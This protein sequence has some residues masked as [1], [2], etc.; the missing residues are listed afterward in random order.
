MEKK[1]DKKR[2][3][4]S[5][6][7][8]IGLVLGIVVGLCLQ[9][10]PD[11]ANNFIKPFGTLF[12]NLV[13]MCIVPLV[14]ASLVMGACGLG[15]IKKLGRVGGKIL[16]YFLCTTAFAVTLGLIVGTLLGVGKG[17][18][19]PNEIDPAAATEAPSVV[20]TLIDIIPTNPFDALVK[21]N[22]LQVI[23]FALFVGIAIAAL[24]AKAEAFKEGMAGF[25]EVMYFIIGS[26]MKLA[27]YAVFALMTPVAATNGPSV[28][29]PLLGL[30]IAVYLTCVLHAAIVYGS[31]VRLVGKTNP[32]TF[33][34]ETASAMAFAFTTASSASTLPFSMESARKLGVP[35]AIRSFVLPLGAT[36][37]MDGTAA[38]QGI[39]VLFIARVY[40]IDLSFSQ[41][42][43]TVLTATLASIGTAGVPGAGTVMLGMVL[44]SIGLPIEGIAIIMGVERIL[45]MA[46]TTVN[47]TGDIAGSVVVAQTEHALFSEPVED[48]IPEG[49]L[50][51]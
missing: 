43:M 23:A 3:N 6:Q 40:G 38:F 7:I 5:V 26:I 33:F 9:G 12:L 2:L 51:T 29:L 37:N 15:D 11:I 10:V 49:T 8:L 21:G 35:S 4:L 13:K 31:L 17:F 16:L 44:Q 28:L 19:M 30:V 45:D 42:L 20:Q 34:R 32:V 50:P 46:R 14:F 24:G 48:V 25:A 27:P 22:M 41:L 18:S 47:I 39:C 1:A 36:I